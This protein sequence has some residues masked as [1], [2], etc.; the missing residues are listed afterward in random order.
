MPLSV[1]CHA[2]LELEQNRKHVQQ[3]RTSNTFVLRRL[4][5]SLAKTAEALAAMQTDD[6]WQ[7]CSVLMQSGSF[8]SDLERVSFGKH[9]LASARQR[10]IVPT[11]SGALVRAV[12][13]RLVSEASQNWLP[14]TLFDNVVPLRSID[15]LR[16]LEALEVPRLDVASI[17]RQIIQHTELLIDQRVALIDGLVRHH[18]P[19]AAHTSALFLDAEG[20][21]LLDDLRVFLAPASGQVPILPEWMDLSFLN[22]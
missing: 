2:T 18:V 5:E 9:M 10:R 12:E 16:F 20:M 7:G 1:V 22:D 3:E 8:P 19:P 13:A 4:A 11:L 14:L 17:K 21:A 15:D 6:P